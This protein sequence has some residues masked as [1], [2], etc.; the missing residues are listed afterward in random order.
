MRNRDAAM[1]ENVQRA[2]LKINPHR[3]VWE[4]LPDGAWAGEQC[5]IVGGGPSLIGFDF[6]R[7]RGKGRIIVINAAYL[8]VPFA[9]VLFFMDGSKTTFYGLVHN[10]RLCDRP[11]CLEAWNN[12][13]GHKVFL[14]LMGRKY[15][16]VHS[17]RSI[18]RMGLSH[19]LRNGL[20]HGNNS[21]VGAVGLAACLHANPIYLLG[22]DC[23]F[24]GGKTHYHGKYPATMTENV[25]KSFIRDFE[26][27]NKFIQRTQFKVVN[28]NPDSGV[29]CFPFSTI[30]EV[31]GDGKV[32]EPTGVGQ[33]ETA[34]L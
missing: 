10:S 25:F 29:R 7:L 26:R 3:P 9:D 16:D 23:K 18:G 4:V 33:A 20:Y 28:L 32:S 30:D 1:A 12:F 31:L 6:E 24:T 13:A 19:S 14:N 8:D 15:D 27:L 17:V 22:I 2:R 34:G 5:F 21:G 11:D